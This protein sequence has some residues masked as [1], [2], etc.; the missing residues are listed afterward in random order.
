M[1]NSRV[2]VREMFDGIE[3]VFPGKEIMKTPLNCNS[4][5][6]TLIC[7]NCGQNRLFYMRTYGSSAIITTTDNGTLNIQ[8]KGKFKKGPI[9]LYGIDDEEQCMEDYEC[10]GKTVPL[11]VELED[12]IQEGY[13]P[14]CA[15]CGYDMYWNEFGEVHDGWCPGCNICEKDEGRKQTKMG[16]VA[17]VFGSECSP[18]EDG[19][20]KCLSFYSRTKYKISLD[21]IYDLV[22]RI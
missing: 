22:K 18:R 8:L 2:Y 13:M 14:Y 15:N 21:E 1:N 19:C 16:C 11:F 20:V 7:V 4:E 10:S 9:K 12:L 17:K 3:K 5:F 6:G